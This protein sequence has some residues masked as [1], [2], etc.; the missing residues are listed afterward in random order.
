MYTGQAA[1][2]DTGSVAQR[3]TSFCC[4]CLKMQSSRSWRLWM[5]TVWPVNK[6]PRGAA[7]LAE[8]LA[9]LIHDLPATVRWPSP[10]RSTLFLSQKRRW[11]RRKD[12]SE[13]AKESNN[14]MTWTKIQHKIRLKGKN[15]FWSVMHVGIVVQHLRINESCS[16][17][18]HISKH[19]FFPEF[20]LCPWH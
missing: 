12:I 5:S 9:R 1:G 15:M 10:N 7:I 2:L 18:M 6:V 14:L 16:W 8:L 19:Q 13:E 20:P 17:L 11:L 4:M 3:S